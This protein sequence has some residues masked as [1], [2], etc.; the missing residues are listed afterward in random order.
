MLLGGVFGFMLAPFVA[1][2]DMPATCSFTPRLSG[3][4]P[5]SVTIQPGRSDIASNAVLNLDGADLEARVRQNGA[6]R[7]RDVLIMAS[8]GEGR[9]IVLALNE[10]GQA[11]LVREMPPGPA[12]QFVGRCGMDRADLRAW[13]A[14]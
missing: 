9:R 1:T 3:G 11:L 6:T 5:V 2:G 7:A 13:F 10:T 4:A 8:D 14:G 12:E